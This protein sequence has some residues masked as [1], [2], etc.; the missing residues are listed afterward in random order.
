MILPL[1]RY[2]DFSDASGR[3]E[4]WHFLLLSLLVGMAARAID[5][6]LGAS[7]L[8]SSSTI[9]L[10]DTSF[11]AGPAEYATF[12][13]L[14]IP[15]ISLLVRR[16]HDIGRTGWFVLLYFIPIV[17]FFLLIILALKRGNRAV[18]CA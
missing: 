13:A 15:W 17:G 6:A 16:L 7:G 5:L 1:R 3:K 9:S 8:V 12:V 2:F 10:F 14:F 11:S 4:F 18:R